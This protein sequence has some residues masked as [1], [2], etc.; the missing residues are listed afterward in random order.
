MMMDDRELKRGPE[1]QEESPGEAHGEQSS[2]SPEAAGGGTRSRRTR[3]KKADEKIAALETEL[4]ETQDRYLRALADLDNFRKRAEKEKGD[5]FRSAGER[6]VANL[7]EVLDGFD[8]ALAVESTSESAEGFLEGISLLRQRFIELLEK[9]G[10]THLDS[11]GQPFDPNL[12][13]AVMQVESE[14]YPPDTVVQE[15]R[16]G[17][18]LNGRLLR[19][20]KVVVAK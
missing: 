17:Y 12:H 8:Q 9:E 11:V 14:G 10:L 20:A 16:R 7:L 4:E 2:T 5:L 13:E 6:I 1:V 19:P 15:L 18:L 3:A